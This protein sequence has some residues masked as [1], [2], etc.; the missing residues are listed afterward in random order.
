MKAT[1]YF[2]VTRKSDEKVT[3]LLIR[4]EKI[5]NN[6]KRIEGKREEM[7]GLLLIHQARINDNDY[8]V[9]IGVCGEDQSYDVWRSMRKIFRIKEDEKE[10]REKSSS[11]MGEENKTQ[12][13]P[14]GRYRKRLKCMNCLLEKH[15]IKDCKEERRCYVCMK[16]GHC[17][18]NYF[19]QTREKGEQF[20]QPGSG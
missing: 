6:W 4:Q 8:H 13:N 20:F 1:E 11:W 19:N 2:T 16:R 18:D 15:F 12:W 9:V 7:E 14:I 17:W 10:K 3:D 5:C